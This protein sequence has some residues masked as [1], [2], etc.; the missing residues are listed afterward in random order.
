MNFKRFLPVA[1]AAGFAIAPTLTAAPAAA[2]S[3][4]T[5]TALGA[6]AGAFAATLLFDSNRNQYYYYNGPRHVYV[7]DGYARRWFAHRDPDYWRAHRHEFYASR[8]GFDR[9]WHG[10]HGDWGHG[11]PR[12]DWHH[13]GGD[14]YHGEHEGRGDHGGWR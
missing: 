11:G 3:Y 8:A 13:E 9:D 5:D 12:G 10:H 6:A 1:L 2:Q 4:G 7:D 14:R